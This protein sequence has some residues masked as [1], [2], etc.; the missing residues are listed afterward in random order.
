MSEL[1]SSHFTGY[2]STAGSLAQL[3]QVQVVQGIRRKKLGFSDACHDHS[4][5]DWLR[6]FVFSFA[7]VPTKR[8][9]LKY[10][11]IPWT[12]LSIFSAHV[13]T[14][15]HNIHIYLFIFIFVRTHICIYIYIYP[16][17]FVYAYDHIGNYKCT[18]VYLQSQGHLRLRDG[19]RKPASLGSGGPWVDHIMTIFWVDEQRFFFFD[20]FLFSRFGHF[21]FGFLFPCFFAF[22]LLCF[23]LFCFSLLL[24][25]YSSLLLCFSIVLPL[26]FSTF[27]LPASLLTCFSAFPFFFGFS[28]CR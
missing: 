5:W 14:H 11:I 4:G 20:L 25:F 27:L 19:P 15:I 23:L 2:V 9:I 12:S 1:I 24:C 26:C 6:N 22:L 10:H 28:Y 3:W 7:D 17:A 8:Y 16:C 13:H 21:F 18:H